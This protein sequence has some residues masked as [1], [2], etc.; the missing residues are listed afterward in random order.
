[1][2]F[3]GSGPS[4]IDLLGGH[5]HGMIGSLPPALPHIKSGKLK[6][7]ATCGLKR[8]VHVPD[9]PTIAEAAIPGFE[10]ASFWGIFAPAGTA[11]PIIAK[12][13]KEIEAVLTS[14]EAKNLFLKQGAQAD[15]MDPTEFGLY[16]AEDL[17][18]WARVVK[19]ANI[20][21]EK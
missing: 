7:L 18:K 14:D 2:H 8:S 5:I 16:I 4:V 3:R 17:A 19:E 9:V 15:Y 21:L 11:A 20:K 13:S 6:V 10:A 1:V 12:L